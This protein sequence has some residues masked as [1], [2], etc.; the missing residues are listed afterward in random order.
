VIS[1]EGADVACIL[2]VRANDRRVDLIVLNIR[3]KYSGGNDRP[4]LIQVIRMTRYLVETIGIFARRTK[5][6]YSRFD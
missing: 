3:K 5:N 2:S 6:G 4:R 1:D